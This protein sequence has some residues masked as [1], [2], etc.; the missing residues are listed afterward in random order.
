MV[1]SESHPV[2]NLRERSKGVRLV[3]K[4]RGLWRAGLTL[5]CSEKCE[6]SSNHCSARTIMANQPDFLAQR[7]MLEEMIIAAGH[8]LPEILL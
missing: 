6:P 5:N 3:L 2:E 4:E 1:L 8:L 7:G